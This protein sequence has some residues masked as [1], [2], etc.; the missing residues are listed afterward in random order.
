MKVSQVVPSVQPA[1]PSSGSV[2]APPV[3]VPVH[4]PSAGVTGPAGPTVP[5]GGLA[6]FA[7]RAPR[8]PGDRK[9]SAAPAH[10]TSSASRSRRALRPPPHLRMFSCPAPGKRWGLPLTV[11]KDSSPLDLIAICSSVE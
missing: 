5:A 8:G 11:S 4:L 3:A 2:V 6:A 1:S 9:R 7:T 10:A